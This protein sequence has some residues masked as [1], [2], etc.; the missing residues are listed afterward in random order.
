MSLFYDK[1]LAPM[2]DMGIAKEV[3]IGD[4]VSYVVEVKP[5]TDWVIALLRENPSLFDDDRPLKSTVQEP[6]IT[7][8]ISKSYKTSCFQIFMG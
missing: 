7:L 5:M 1:L 4:A 8:N 3:K 2:L 6:I